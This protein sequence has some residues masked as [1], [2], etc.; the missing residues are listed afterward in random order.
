MHKSVTLAKS[1]T[2]AHNSLIQFSTLEAESVRATESHL[3]ASNSNKTPSTR[4]IAIFG[5][6]RELHVK[7][8]LRE[9]GL[10]RNLN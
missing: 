4:E 9:K 3:N 1:L 6:G 8:Y 5:H 7:P 10:I 2:L